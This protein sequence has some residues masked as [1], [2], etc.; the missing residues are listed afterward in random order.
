[1]ALEIKESKK[2]EILVLEPVGRLDTKSSTEF[3]KKVLEQLAEGQRRY[4]ITLKSVEYLSSAGLRILLMLAKKLSGGDGYLALCEIPPQV[5]E[6]FDI[7]GFTSV[8]TIKGS[9][10]DAVA[11]A[12]HGTRSERV[13]EQAAK[14]LGLSKSTSRTSAADPALVERAAKVLGA[15]RDEAQGKKEPATP[16]APKVDFGNLFKR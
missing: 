8:F 3:E 2:D 11:G 15:A 14:A 5:K 6:V 7:A 10:D 9:V 12:P 16:E 4:V 13:A 1:M